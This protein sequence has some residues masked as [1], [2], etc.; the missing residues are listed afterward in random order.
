MKLNPF[1]SVYVQAL[2]LLAALA[3]V[4]GFFHFQDYQRQSEIKAARLDRDIVQ[5]QLMFDSYLTSLVQDTQMLAHSP[6]LKMYLRSQRPANRTAEN[7]FLTLSSLRHDYDQIRYID[8]FGREKIRVDRRN[9]Y[10]GIRTT[11]LQD[12][13]DRAYVQAGFSL[14]NGNVW[15]SEID[16]NT[17]YG[18]IKSP[19]Q[20]VV[21]AVSRVEV[22]GRQKGL[23]IINAKADLL[24]NRLA[25]VLSEPERLV[26][27]NQSGGWIAGGENWGFME[28]DGATMATM[29]PELWQSIR[30]TSQ[31]Q[32]EYQ[33]ECY[34]YRWHRFSKAGV[35]SP[36]WLLAE[37]WLGESCSAASV[38]AASSA[39][40]WFLGSTLFTMPLLLLW[41][42]WRRRAFSLYET[43]KDSYR[44]LDLVTREARH[45]LLMV[46]KDCRVRWMNPE[47]ERLLG[48]KEAE[49]INR[50]LHDTT[51]VLPDGQSLHDG[52]CPTLKA[53]RTGQRY[54]NDHDGLINRDGDILDLSIR[55]SPDGDGEGR[56]AIIAIADVREHVKL[57]QQLNRLATTDELTGAVNRRSILQTLEEILA[58]RRARPAVLMLD[59]DHF[60]KVNDTY[61]HD[62]GDKIL[63]KFS[64]TIQKLLRV[65]DHLARMGGE[66]FLV[67]ASD[68][69][70]NDAQALAERIRQSVKAMQCQ[71]QDGDTVS[72][73]VSIGVALAEPDESVDALLIRADKALYRAK[74][75]GRN[76]VEVSKLH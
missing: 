23:V 1:L 26:L 28:T 70:G 38:Q 35:Q 63:E 3:S 27:L 16:L 53:L 42:K 22:D 5:M 75:A 2:I 55:V 69:A 50:N 18:R 74:G 37:R 45:G 40:F 52:E 68:I 10:F 62:A 61:G 51:H 8:A 57:E 6:V 46:D 33:G 15:L 24:L 48:W 60:K 47:A 39:A 20:P 44:Q 65:E 19:H 64:A 58:D 73:T 14:A 49:L 11:D 17:E 72:I 66:E 32:F 30:N 4:I 76:R 29:A 7:V 12:E 54:H 9:G 25:V 43:L 56:Q 71:T 31:G 13:S 59:I 36:R 21:R 41:H 67:V 34:I